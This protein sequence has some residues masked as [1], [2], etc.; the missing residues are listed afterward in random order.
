MGRNGLLRE[1]IP[2][3]GSNE[4]LGGPALINGQKGSDWE[5]SRGPWLEA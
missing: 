1:A 3:P 2:A 5:A 4:L